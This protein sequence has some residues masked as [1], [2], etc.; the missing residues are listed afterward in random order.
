[1]YQNVPNI[2][3]EY[4]NVLKSNNMYQKLPKT[5]K[6]YQKLP[7]SAKKKQQKSIQKDLKVPNSTKKVPLGQKCN[8]K[9]QIYNI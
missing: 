3:K 5:T 8:T 6:N 9:Y 2:T 7:K 4:Q 1:M